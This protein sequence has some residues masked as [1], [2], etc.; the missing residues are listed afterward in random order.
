MNAPHLINTSLQRG[1]VAAMGAANRFSGFQRRG[2]PL[3]RFAPRRAPFPPAEAG[4]YCQD[5]GI[6]DTEQPLTPALSPS[7]G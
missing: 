5:R 4:C 6:D 3:K 2:K 7:E 1:E